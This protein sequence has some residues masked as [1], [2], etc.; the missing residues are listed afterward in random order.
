MRYTRPEPAVRSLPIFRGPH[1][2]PSVDA[3]LVEHES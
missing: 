1:G 3:Q 2:D